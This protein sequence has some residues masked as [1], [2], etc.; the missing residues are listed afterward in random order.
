[1]LKIWST[2]CDGFSRK[3]FFSGRGRTKIW[4]FR[5]PVV[6]GQWNF[7]Q[8]FSIEE[9]KFW[10][11]GILKKFSTKQDIFYYSGKIGSFCAALAFVLQLISGTLLETHFAYKYIQNNCLP[12]VIQ[13]CTTGLLWELRILVPNVVLDLR[14]VLLAVFHLTIRYRLSV[15]WWWIESAKQD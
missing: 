13:K 5:E 9:A 1:M 15:R 11:K 3:F 10:S 12:E 4:F 7:Q 8:C 2:L 6:H 14:N